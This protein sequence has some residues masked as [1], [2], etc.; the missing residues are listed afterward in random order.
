MSLFAKKSAAEREYEAVVASIVSTPAL[1]R[2]THHEWT[3]A[4]EP[5]LQTKEVGDKGIT[6]RQAEYA[7]TIGNEFAK[8]FEDESGRCGYGRIIESIPHGATLVYW[9]W[10][11]GLAFPRHY[12][13]WIETIIFISGLWRM[14]VDGVVSV[15]GPGAS[16]WIPSG[17]PHSGVVLERSRLITCSIPELG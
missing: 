3:M 17:T 14:D 9:E 11:D 10:D 15:R 16:I 6:F 7:F 1:R 4:T 12:H 13:A 8:V 2:A 5:V